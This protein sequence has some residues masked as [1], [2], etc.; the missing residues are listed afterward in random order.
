MYFGAQTDFFYYAPSVTDEEDHVRAWMINDFEQLVRRKIAWAYFTQHWFKGLAFPRASVLT[1]W[2]NGQIPFIR[3]QPHTGNLYGPPPNQVYPEQTFSLQ[4]IIDGEFDQPLR[5]WADAAGE[6]DIPILVEF[7][8]EINGDWGPWNAKWNGAGQTDGYGDPT[9]PDGAERYRDAYRHL[10][11]LFRQEGATNVT[12]F[13][14]VDAYRQYDWWNELKW[15]YPGDD[16]VDWLGISNYGSCC[17]N[18][19]P[20][21]GFGEKLDASLVYDDLARISAQPMAVLETGVVENLTYPKPAWTRDAFTALHSGRYPRIHGVA[22]W[23]TSPGGDF[24]VSVDTS[25]EALA[26]FRKGIANPFFGAKPRFTGHCRPPAPTGLV[27]RR[28]RGLVSVKWRTRLDSTSYEIWRGSRRLGTSVT[29]RYIDRQPRH[30]RATYRLRGRN[31]LG[32][33]PFSR[34]VKAR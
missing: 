32:V 17:D 33:G 19:N 9:Y 31:P 4:H 34:A 23:Q 18:L 29:G 24:N 5:A 26:A 15:Y 25:P 27:A 12:W 2:R 6:A 30:G 1:V 16:Y 7:G 20:V 22:V 13:F 11:T 28:T 10:V 21:Q 14:H 8:T 3:L